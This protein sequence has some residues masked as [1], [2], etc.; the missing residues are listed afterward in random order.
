MRGV[1]TAL[2]Q[3]SFN[4]VIDRTVKEYLDSVAAMQFDRRDIEVRILATPEFQR[5]HD[6][7][8]QYL[9]DIDLETPMIEYM[10][11]RVYSDLSEHLG[12][13]GTKDLIEVLAER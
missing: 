10:R 3:L 1:K 9:A 5:I 11:K 6:I 7:Q 13:D 2:I 12:P 4:E 8:A